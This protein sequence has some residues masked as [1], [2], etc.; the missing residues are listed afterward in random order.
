MDNGL[1]VFFNRA[2]DILPNLSNGQRAM[3]IEMLTSGQTKE[4]KDFL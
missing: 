4:P 1:N 2:S 3:L